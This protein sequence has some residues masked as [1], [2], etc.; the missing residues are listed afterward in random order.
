MNNRGKL[1][2]GNWKLNS[3]KQ[4]MQEMLID[5]GQAL[6]GEQ[7]PA[8]FKLALCT[9]SIY[10]RE[11]V[12]LAQAASDKLLIGCKNINTDPHSFTGDFSA[13]LAQEAGCKLCLVGHAERRIG[14]NEGD[15][16]YAIKVRQLLGAGVAPALCIGE[17]LEE[18]L[19]GQTHAVL[20]LQ[21]QRA[22]AGIE[23]GADQT[24]YIVYEPAYAISCGQA[25]TP[26]FA[27]QVHADIRH[28]LAEL[29]GAAQAQ[30]IAIIYGGSVNHDNAL[31]LIAQADV[32]GLLIA[33]ASSNLQHFRAICNRV[34]ALAPVFNYATEL[35]DYE[36]YMDA[37]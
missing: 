15:Y 12:K 34:F 14:L 23:L 25:L 32:D 16:S 31:S 17:T 33:C 5:L 18:K 37:S 28:L 36:N 24:L 1:I 10:V 8:N 29:L 7:A 19:A 3:S 9:P 11:M 27:Q 13:A 26:V 4:V 30:R 21:L 6:T 2:L 20:R 35:K 22:L